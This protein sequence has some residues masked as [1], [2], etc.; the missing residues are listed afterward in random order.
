MSFSLRTKKNILITIILLGGLAITLKA[1]HWFYLE[2][3]YQDTA[4][5]SKQQM[6]ELVNF[7]DGSLSRYES[8]PHV[9]S[10]NP[11]L[12]N[13]LLNQQDGKSIQKLNLYLEEI[14]H[15]T[16]SLDIYLVDALGVSIAASNWQ[17]SYSFIGKDFSF[18]PYYQQ[19][20]SGQLGR[21][22]AVGTTSN[23]RGF[24]FSYPVYE[25][26]SILG[27]IVVKLDITEI[28]QQSTGI[29]RA[30]GY[31]FAI[32][33][34]DNIIF[35]SS[36]NHW[37]LRSLTPLDQ[38][39]Q[40]AIHASKRYASRVINELTLSPLY[41]AGATDEHNLYAFSSLKG[42]FDY[43]ETHKAMAKAGWSVHIMAPLTPI[44][45]SLPLL[46]TLYGSLY[47]LLALAALFGYERR[48]NL[49][50]IQ[51]ANDLLEQRVQARTQDLQASN[52]KLNETQ[53]ELIQAAK[54]TVIGNLSASI[55]HE[56]NQPLAAI[57][58]YA[59]NTKTMI[60]RNQTEMVTDNINTI[61]S[62]TDR[63]AVIVGQFKSFTRKSQSRD[64][65]TD[66]NQC[67]QDALT[68]I[69]PEIDKQGVELLYRANEISGQVWA[70]NVRLQQVLVNL[71]SNAIVAM[72]RSAPKRLS[73]TLVL[74]SQ[75]C[76]KIQDTG[77]G[78][79][80]SQMEKIFEP[81]FTTSDRQG[82]GLGLSISRRIIDSM[83]GS[84]R[85]SNAQTG[86][87]IFEITLP[88]YSSNKA[89]PD[90]ASQGDSF[91]EQKHSS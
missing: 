77:S 54:L 23:K 5:R 65:A 15:I 39:R 51:Q 52:R 28:E 49:L 91:N 22:Y 10:T 1:T 3:G 6:T 81:F 90:H 75:L 44:Y 47:L 45:Q 38:S 53:D 12:K 14:K 59:Q 8:I 2:Q 79:Q 85:V 80:E 24:Y 89:S 57:R 18:R 11:L 25:Q 66:I 27:V 17:K 48:K 63:L 29:A 86:G 32:T 82:L 33:D 68:I 16:E 56:I 87:A 84:I 62:L 26:Q 71:M 35:L 83:Q 74:E 72:Q 19:A 67:I 55:N 78:V 37:R 61:I 31:E 60:S 34:P 69:K 58:S 20:I 21:Y 76:I 40:Y 42:Q 36:I 41:D 4:E 9:L 43:M 50:R 30:G 7:L 70:D 64:S 46:M 88:V 73:L 13:A